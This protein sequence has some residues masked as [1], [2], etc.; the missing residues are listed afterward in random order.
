MS[1]QTWETDGRWRRLR[2]SNALLSEVLRGNAQPCQTDAPADLTVLAINHVLAGPDGELTFLVW[3]ASFEPV[4]L[5]ADGRLKEDIPFVE[6]VYRRV[7][8]E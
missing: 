6:F 5:D 7:L 3:S 4:L 8:S 2:V 1:E